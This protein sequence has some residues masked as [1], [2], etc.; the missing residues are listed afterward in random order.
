MCGD[1][2]RDRMDEAEVHHKLPFIGKTH[3]R[4]KGLCSCAGTIFTTMNCEEQKRLLHEE[5]EAWAAHKSLAASGSGD[6]KEI[7]AL[8]DNA[9]DASRRVR[10]HIRTCP[11]C[12]LTGE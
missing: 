11:T 4:G 8:C 5:N 7:Q 3:Q 6:L 12:H 9:I 2:N 10:Q 1:L